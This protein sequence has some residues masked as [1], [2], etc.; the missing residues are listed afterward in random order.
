MPLYL[1]LTDNGINTRPVRADTPSD[2]LEALRVEA[3]GAAIRVAAIEL[4]TATDMDTDGTV[5]QEFTTAQNN[6]DSLVSKARQAL[7]VNDAYLALSDP[8]N[9]QN[10]AQIRAVTRECSALIRLLLG[11]LDSTAGT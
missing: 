7:T 8:T 6:R 3:H 11:Q 1:I 4:L 5:P 9:S 10:L 2:L